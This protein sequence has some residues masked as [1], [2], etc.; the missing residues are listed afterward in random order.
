MIKNRSDITIRSPKI[1]DAQSVY[2]LIVT[3]DIAEY[4]EPDSTLGDLLDEWSSINLGRDAWLVYA[5]N[6]LL[7]GYA[8]VFAEGDHFMFDFF[9]HPDVGKGW[10]VIYLLERCEAHAKQLLLLEGDEKFGKVRVII[11]SVNESERELVQKAG[12]EINKYYF[13]MQIEMHEPPRDVSWPKDFNIR[14]IVPGKDDAHVYEFVRAAFQ[15]PGRTFPAYD[16]WKGYMM[17]ADHFERDLWFLLF[18]GVE[19]IGVALCYDYSE[20][21]WV[22][23]LAVS[24]TWRRKGI[25]S[26]LLHYVFRVFYER[27]H[28]KV[29]LGVDSERSNAYRLYENVGMQRVRQYNEYE[30]GIQVN[31]LGKD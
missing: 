3:C 30:K 1:D 26:M 25:G 9:T 19:L 2:Q 23:Q 4:G 28:Q 24:E 22:R 15:R 21:G 17:R 12:Y 31:E 10:L 8:A 16:R 7:V 5:Q 11:P 14:I 20:Y 18:S 27:G 29:A 13:R 6:E